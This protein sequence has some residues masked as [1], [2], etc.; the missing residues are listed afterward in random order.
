MTGTPEQLNWGY[1]LCVG[2]MKEH[3]DVGIIHASTRS[4]TALPKDYVDR[5]TSAHTA[6]ASQAY[7]EG[8]FINLSEGMVYYGFDPHIN[9][10]TIEMPDGAELGV[11][12]DFNVN[13]MAAVVF[14]R[15]RDQMHY[16]KE[17]E[18]PNADT[19]F[20]CDTLKDDF[21]GI[22]EVYPDASG[23]QRKTA[24]PAGKSDFHYIQEAGLVVCSH[25][26]NPHRRDRYN[27]V[28]GK[29]APKKDK[30]TLTV[31]PSCK[32]L[33][34][35]FSLYAF[36]ILNKQESMSHLLDAAGYPVH[37]LFP[38]NKEVLEQHRLVGV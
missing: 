2:Q 27:A 13:P 9:V 33:I 25:A 1:D 17:Y 4:N 32:S 34:K 16:I 15:L 8:Q 31:D 26:A 3:N 35:Y 29:L 20:M 21:P 6:K 5:L 22:R 18:L 7:V 24:S 30:P 10:Q 19:Q 23:S 36:D 14:W 28:N 37:Y 38:V 11:G 12:M